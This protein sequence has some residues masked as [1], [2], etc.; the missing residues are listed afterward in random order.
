MYLPKNRYRIE[1][2]DP[3]DYIGSYRGKV[4]K[5]ANGRVFE[6][7]SLETAGRELSR[8]PQEATV[9]VDRPFNEYP[10]PTL[11]DYQKGFVTRY[12]LYERTS[13]R[14]YEVQLNQYNEKRNNS[15]VESG[16]IVWV[17]KKPIED[18]M[19]QRAGNSVKVKGAKTL[20]QETVTELEKLYPGISL[21]FSNPTEFLI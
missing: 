1:Q 4:I 20:N 18:V 19:M 2:A 9:Q 21:L 5:A 3:N 12:F 14:A 13:R 15:G 17:L 10:K 6:G 7:S 8:V 16:K 11:Q